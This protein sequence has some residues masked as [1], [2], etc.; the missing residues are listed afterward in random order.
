MVGNVQK[1]LRGTGERQKEDQLYFLVIYFT[2]QQRISQTWI[3]TST[4]GQSRKATL[5]IVQL[6]IARAW[7]R[8]F[9]F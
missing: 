7:F 6:E 2:L 3:V 5:E 1:L 8:N 4:L 9:D